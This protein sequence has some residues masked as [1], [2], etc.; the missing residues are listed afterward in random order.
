VHTAIFFA[1]IPDK[2]LQGSWE[3]EFGAAAS[4]ITQKIS[5]NQ[6]GR[7]VWQVDFERAPGDLAKLI[8]LCEEHAVSYQILP[9]ADAPKWIRWNSPQGL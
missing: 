8:A 4:S 7:Y 3:R 9:L 1:V 2:A 5:A 6:L